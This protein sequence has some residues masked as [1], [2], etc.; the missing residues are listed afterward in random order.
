MNT[1]AL[2]AFGDA[3]VG[4]R[5]WIFSPVTARSMRMPWGLLVFAWV[6]E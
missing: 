1:F 6:G 3:H 4:H 2:W 5:R